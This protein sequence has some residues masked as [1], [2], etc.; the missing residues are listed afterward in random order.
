[1]R[2]RSS[3]P[4]TGSP[5]KTLSSI[6]I[7]CCL[8]G[9]RCSA[10]AS[11]G[12]PCRCCCRYPQT[13]PGPSGSPGA[14]GT[15]DAVLHRTVRLL[16]PDRLRP[17]LVDAVAEGARLPPPRRQLL[18][19]RFV[20]REARFP[21]RRLHDGRFLPRP[22]HRVVHVPPPPQAAAGDQYHRQPGAALLLQVHE[23]L[24][25]IASAGAAWCQP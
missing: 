23:L 14:G 22:G 24:P 18:L 2:C 17:L 3:T 8:K 19:L 7:T 12:R 6:R 13:D 16:L 1:M 4:T 21:D 11:A 10:A 25:R 9:P 5:R 20:E 15:D